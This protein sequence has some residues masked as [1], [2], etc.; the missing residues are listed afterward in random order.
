MLVKDDVRH[1]HEFYQTVTAKSL[2]FSKNCFKKILETK[3]TGCL[4]FAGYKYY[5]RFRK[6]KFTLSKVKS[7]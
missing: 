5:G 6:S 2:F 3:N 7:E 1:F 4:N